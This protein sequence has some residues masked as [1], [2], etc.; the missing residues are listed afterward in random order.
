MP[1]HT[2]NVSELRIVDCITSVLRPVGGRGRRISVERCS[3]VGRMCSP[4]SKSA[5]LFRM[6]RSALNRM[7]Q[8]GRNVKTL[9]C[10]S[11]AELESTASTG[12]QIRS[13]IPGVLPFECCIRVSRSTM[14]VEYAIA[15]SQTRALFFVVRHLMYKPDSWMK[16][17][18]PSSKR[19]TFVFTYSWN[20]YFV[21]LNL[22][23]CASRIAVKPASQWNEPECVHKS[24]GS[25][26]RL[27]R[28]LSSCASPQHETTNLNSSEHV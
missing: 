18:R 21:S 26:L 7:I 9:R 2:E 4:F 23:V 11:V 13:S 6:N 20:V 3:H 17:D 19:L 15:G 27:S 1:Q 25:A 24:N 8:L 14:P 16:M 12:C 10:N 28:C 5:L 22:A